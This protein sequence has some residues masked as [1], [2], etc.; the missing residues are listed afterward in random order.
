MIDFVHPDSRPVVRERVQRMLASGQAEPLLEERF[1]RLDGTPVEVEVAAGPFTYLGQP[2][3]QV[4]FRDIAERKRLRKEL[5]HSQAQQAAI[6]AA[7]PVAVYSAEV[8]G[9]LDA[10]WMSSSIEHFT[11]FPAERFMTEPHFWSSRLHPDDREETLASYRTAIETG[12]ARV[13]YRWQVRDGSFRWLSDH[14]VGVARHESTMHV[15][16][17][18]ADI[19]ERRL[20][21]QALRDS[22]EKY[23]DLVEKIGEAIFTVDIDGTLTFISA[24]AHRIIGFEPAELMG[25]H[26]SSFIHP[27]DLPALV[28]SFERTIKGTL[29]PSEYRVVHKTGGHRWV[30]SSS[31]PILHGEQ[32]VGL[33]GVLVDI[34]ERREAELALQHYARR[35]ESM[36]DIDLAILAAR[37]LKEIA[38]AALQRLRQL[39]PAERAAI[40]AFHPA[41]GDGEYVAVD[42][43]PESRGCRQRSGPGRPLPA[44]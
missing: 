32:P 44:G 29:H 30:R 20:A 28:D 11:G 23:R 5:D 12:E 24:A 39:I 26:F 35:L 31:Q 38:T 36:H 3:I 22:E 19:S 6:L 17:V 37:S 16:G 4:V 8:P 41:T 7:L 18:I 1:Q 2:A 42:S 9:N 10:M 27:E 25:R 43:V 33:R 15:I 13:E 40:V 34:T 21:E 14:A